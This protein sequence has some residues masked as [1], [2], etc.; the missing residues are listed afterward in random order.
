MGLSWFP[1]ILQASP[2]VMKI[3]FSATEEERQDARTLRVLLQK[4]L[5]N[6]TDTPARPI[7]QS[8]LHDIDRFLANHEAGREP[9]AEEEGSSSTEYS[10]LDALFSFW[11]FLIGPSSREVELG[12]QRAELIERAEH[13]ESSAFEALAELAELKQEHSTVV[14]KLKKLEEELADRG[15]TT[16]S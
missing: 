12:K 11:H 15:K 7:I 1:G 9:A 13:A 5:A 2:T 4:L 10:P 3:D 6:E 8:L 14:Q 16:Q